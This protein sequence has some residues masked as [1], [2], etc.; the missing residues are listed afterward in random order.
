MR[1]E[2]NYWVNEIFYEITR[3]Q[4]SLSAM[5]Q[6]MSGEPRQET[7]SYNQKVMKPIKILFQKILW[8]TKSS[9]SLTEVIEGLSD[10]NYEIVLK[11]EKNLRSLEQNNWYWAIIWFLVKET[12]YGMTK[13]DWHDMFWQS[14]L[15]VEYTGPNGVIYYRIRSTTDLETDEFTDFIEK[16]LRFCEL[17]IKDGWL[18][19]PRKFLLPKLK[20]LE[21]PF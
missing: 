19:I 2:K 14:F 7:I 21:P 1:M 16:I 11:T 9:Q 13:D 15:K 12:S 3:H 8:Q 18:W 5:I 4:N 10:G 17:P 6:C 20:G